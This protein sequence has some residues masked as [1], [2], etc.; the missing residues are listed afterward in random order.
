M[1]PLFFPNTIQILH[2]F[3]DQIDVEGVIPFLEGAYFCCSAYGE[4]AFLMLETALIL[5]LALHYQGRTLLASLFA[6]IYFS[7]CVV[8]FSDTLPMHILW[9]GQVLAA[10][11][12]IAG[13]VCSSNASRESSQIRV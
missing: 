7:A 8:C 12:V 3:L 9:W 10:P 5:L 4:G 1:S 6:L 2:V 11:T 13:K